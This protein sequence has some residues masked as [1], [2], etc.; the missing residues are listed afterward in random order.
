MHTENQQVALQM[1]SGLV[2][3]RSLGAM[4]RQILPNSEK[5]LG[6]MLCQILP[7]TVEEYLS[8]VVSFLILEKSGGIIFCRILLNTGN[9]LGRMSCQILLNREKRFGTIFHHILLNTGGEFWNCVPLT[10]SFILDMSC[11]TVSLLAALKELW[12]L[13]KQS[14]LYEAHW[15]GSKPFRP[16]PNNTS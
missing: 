9:C 6:R 10:S 2:L 7:N 13:L 1:I 8:S 4:F 16:K 14:V 3:E 12:L 5:S 15:E 11:E